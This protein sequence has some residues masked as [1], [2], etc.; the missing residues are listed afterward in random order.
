MWKTLTVQIA[1]LLV[2]ATLSPAGSLAAYAGSATPA[3]ALPQ[4]EDLRAAA[5]FD[6]PAGKDAGRGFPVAFKRWIFSPFAWAVKSPMMAILLSALVAAGALLCGRMMGNT[7][8]H[9]GPGDKPGK[10][11]LF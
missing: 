5:A 6:L 2:A 10:P 7:R 9:R 4:A 1:I 11:R 3:A 8:R